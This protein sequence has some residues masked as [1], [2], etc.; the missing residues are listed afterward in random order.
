MKINIFAA[1][2]CI[3]IL[4]ANSAANAQV[5]VEM[6]FFMHEPDY[7][8]IDTLICGT[9]TVVT[10]PIT[11]PSFPSGVFFA[12]WLID[13]G[14]DYTREDIQP[15]PPN[16]APYK[17]DYLISF[18]LEDSQT[19]TL[20]MAWDSLP[21]QID[22][23]RISYIGLDTVTLKN[24]YHNEVVVD[25]L[26]YFNKSGYDI[27]MLLVTVY[28]NASV[29]MPSS[30]N[31]LQAI[32][33]T[34]QLTIFPDPAT[35]YI[36]I[37]EGEDPYISKIVLYNMLGEVIKTLSTNYNSRGPFINRMDLSGVPSGMYT[38]AAY[39]GVHVTTAQVAVIK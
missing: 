10:Q 16:I 30:V 14:Y 38:V 26:E 32:K 2:F 33:P 7:K 24:I 29:E 28:Y 34:P 11:W 23:V 3:S 20:V 4:Y 8:A 31:Q 13:S 21:S 37:T 25:S 18:Q 6:S 17:N 19:D 35:N 15:I 22:S 9:Q 12:Y 5:N 1:I 36:A 27:T 39:D